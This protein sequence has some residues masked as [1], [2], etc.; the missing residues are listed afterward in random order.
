MSVPAWMW[1]RSRNML[2][3]LAR[4]NGSV[5]EI[6]GGTGDE[7][8]SGQGIGRERADDPEF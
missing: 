3:P 6:E 8:L 2:R 5:S 4:E 7:R 1:E